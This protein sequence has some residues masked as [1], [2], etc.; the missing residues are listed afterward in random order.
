MANIHVPKGWSLPESKATSES[1]YFNRREFV[2]TAGAGSIFAA[3]AVT[4]VAACDTGRPALA[5]ERGPLDNVPDTP[6]AD[7][8]PAAAKDGR[9][10]PGER[11]AVSD[12]QVVATYN[13][14]YE[15]GTDKGGVW[16]HVGPF[17]ARPWQLEVTGMVNNPGRWDL[18]ELEREFPL[19]ERIYRHRCVEAWSVVVP[20]IGFPLASLLAR[21]EPQNDARFV[22][23]VSFDN[24]E[25][26]IG[27]KEQTWY[28]WPYYEAVRLD[29]AMNELSFVVTGMYGHPLQ[30]QNGAPVR[31]HMPWKYGYKSPKSIVRIEVGRQASPTFWNDLAPAE[32][33]FYSNVDPGVPHPRWTQAS[34][35]VV[36]TGDRI[37][38]LPFN[39]YG[40][41][42]AD[43]Y[44]GL[45]T[46]KGD[47][48]H[49]G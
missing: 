36:G 25:Q 13:N 1:A 41:Y 9:F 38:T 30:K 27:Q 10:V 11:R 3:A 23:F 22:R 34:E 49:A 7:L 40:E 45:V 17:E 35:R 44:G 37:P 21:A 42:V 28:K 31:M 4:G 32:Y 18:A 43:L 26:A 19:E 5:Q 20:W 14:F 48:P 15:F 8:Y 2:K 12:E 46:P 16:R 47:V 33:G 6:T 39:G 24:P 29:E